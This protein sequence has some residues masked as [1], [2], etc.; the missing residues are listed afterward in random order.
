[1]SVSVSFGESER[2]PCLGNTRHRSGPSVSFGAKRVVS[3]RA[4]PFF[5]SQVAWS[6]YGAT[7]CYTILRLRV[8]RFVGSLDVDR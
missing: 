5:G 4:S 1:M 2:F 3:L 8:V 7:G 6:R